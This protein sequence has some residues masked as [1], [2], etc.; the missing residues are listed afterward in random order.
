MSDEEMDV[1]VIPSGTSQEAPSS[2]QGGT[3]NLTTAGPT[4]LRDVTSVGTNKPF[5]PRQD[6]MEE[7]AVMEEATP[8]NT[9]STNKSEKAKEK[10]D[11]HEYKR[12]AK[13]CN[14]FVGKEATDISQDEFRLIGVR[15]R[16]MRRLERRYPHM[17]KIHVPV[18]QIPTP[19]TADPSSPTAVKGAVVPG[20]LP[21]PGVSGCS[22]SLQ[23]PMV[24]AAETG[25][26]MP[27]TLETARRLMSSKAPTV[28]PSEQ[29]KGQSGTTQ[30][31]KATPNASASSVTA[32]SSV[33]V[34]RSSDLLRTSTMQRPGKQ[35]TEASKD[36]KKPCSLSDGGVRIA[37]GATG[38][39]AGVTDGPSTSRQASGRPKTSPQQSCVKRVRSS[40]DP[41]PTA[42]RMLDRHQTNHPPTLAKV[43]AQQ[44]ATGVEQER[45]CKG[46]SSPAP[47]QSSAG[48]TSKPARTRRKLASRDVQ[49]AIIDRS[50]PEGWISDDHWLLVERLLR[51]AITSD[52]ADASMTG[53]GKATYIRGVKV[54]GCQDEKSKDYL[55]RTV[56]GSGALWEGCKLAAVP[57]SEI[58]RRASA[59]VWVPPP[60]QEV[61]EVLKMIQRQNRGLSTASWRFIN[62]TKEGAGAVM[63]FTMDNESAD[64]IRDCEGEL[65]FGS[66]WL[67]FRVSK[68]Q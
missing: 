7:E 37:G 4:P 33:G 29:K 6:A 60:D 64:Y 47:Q 21:K 41:Q 52:E 42:K 63:K 16:V 19:G 15:L 57:T 31:L 61:A 2:A 3:S 56:D 13:Y 45:S 36:P 25:R 8:S 49:I 55:I 27:S 66:G 11:R 1:T 39:M 40:E 20:N 43:A 5:L 26:R 44:T 28:L 35:A 17:E 9:T 48:G 51:K 24:S 14:K 10:K 54:I 23:T 32:P 65:Y 58:P 59:T 46:S 30:M 53:F 22:D 18:N 50:D 67:R 68:P 62:S 12:A 34:N 38:R